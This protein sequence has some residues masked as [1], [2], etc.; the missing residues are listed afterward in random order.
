MGE[1]AGQEGAKWQRS[2]SLD[3]ANSKAAAVFSSP[4][5]GL[6]ISPGEGDN[7]HFPLSSY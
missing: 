1:G 7:S 6:L 5:V 4:L 2:A 3:Q